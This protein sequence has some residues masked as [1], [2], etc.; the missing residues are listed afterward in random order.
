MHFR[1]ASRPSQAGKRPRPRCNQV[2]KRRQV[3][4]DL[5]CLR[6]RWIVR[7]ARRCS[8]VLSSAHQRHSTR[9]GRNLYRY[10]ID[11]L[12]PR[13]DPCRDYRALGRDRHR[14]THRGKDRSRS[15]KQSR[16]HNRLAQCSKPAP[17]SRW[18]P[19][20]RRRRLVQSLCMAKPESSALQPLH[21]E[22]ASKT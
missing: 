19:R 8:C 1:R 22:C 2:H 14:T 6:I 9:W 10:R 11:R 4:K 12:A 16:L 17:R 18:R 15:R 3:G 20:C 13:I 21:G 5:S 7:N